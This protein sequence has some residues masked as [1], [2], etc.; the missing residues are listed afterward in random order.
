M[1][2][3]LDAAEAEHKDGFSG[4]EEARWKQLNRDYDQVADELRAIEEHDAH[5]RSVGHLPAELRGA[6]DG[7][8]SDRTISGAR[9]GVPIMPTLSEY[10]QA[11][12]RALSEGTAG[13]G[14][15]FVPDQQAGTWFDML[16]ARSVVLQAGPVMIEA[17]SDTVRV[18]K[19]ATGT[20]V[21][22]TAENASI[23]QGDPTFSEVVLTPRKAAALTLVSNEVLEDSSPSVREVLARDH[24]E[25]V[26]LLLDQQFLAGN[27]TAPNMRGIRN[28]TGVSSTELGANGAQIAFD[29]LADQLDRLR[30][31]NAGACPAWFMHLRTWAAVAKLK[32]TTNRYLVGP[33]PTVEAPMRLFGIPVYISNQISIAETQG[34]ANNA[35]HII[36]ADMNQIVVAQR[37]AIQVEYSRDFAFGSDQTAVRTV[38]RY[39]IKPINVAGVE[40]VVGVIP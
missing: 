40:L 7:Y 10:R 33:D 15:Y 6:I 37:K 9:H 38:A 32:D 29:N 1:R 39:D 35:S 8:G 11:E 30:R 34:S 5:E 24:L 23:S 4:A 31:S 28:F 2:E 3:M 18:P 21:S 26:A 20:V 17:N 25:Q 22:M 14:G 16:R 27:G 19:V 36:L 13:A 12:Q